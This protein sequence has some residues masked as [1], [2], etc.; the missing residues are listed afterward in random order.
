MSDVIHQARQWWPV[1]VVAVAYG[2]A[3]LVL[4]QLPG[5]LL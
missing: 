1:A 3:S 2:L 4:L 5:W